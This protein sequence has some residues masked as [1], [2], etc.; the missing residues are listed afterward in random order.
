M[1]KGCRL[2]E[3]LIRHI[4]CIKYQKYNSL[5]KAESCVFLL[6]QIFLA[7]DL[8]SFI[9]TVLCSAVFVARPLRTL[10]LADDPVTAVEGGPCNFTPH[11]LFSAFDV[12]LKKVEKLHF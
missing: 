11:L 12:I 1:V 3:A 5:N 7:T 2:G 8:T 10:G 6:R 4:T 9:V